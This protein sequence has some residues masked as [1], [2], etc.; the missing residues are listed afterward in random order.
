VCVWVVGYGERDNTLRVVECKSYLDSRGVALRAFDGKDAKFAE[1]F[2][3][4][5]HPSKL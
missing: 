2:A 4:L 5:L 3:P 1:R